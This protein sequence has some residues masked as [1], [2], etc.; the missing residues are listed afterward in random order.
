MKVL[1][2]MEEVITVMVSGEK[3]E[4]SIHIYYNKEKRKKTVIINDSPTEEYLFSNQVH[5]SQTQLRELL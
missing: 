2:G 1:E 3:A 4:N 5:L